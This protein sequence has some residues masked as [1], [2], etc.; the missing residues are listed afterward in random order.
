MFSWIH[1]I[2][3]CKATDQDSKCVWQTHARS[4]VQTNSEIGYK[5]KNHNNEFTRSR[6]YNIQ[7]PRALLA[8]SIT[9][10]KIWKK[11]WRFSNTVLGVLCATHLRSHAEQLCGTWKQHGTQANIGTGTALIAWR[12]TL[13]GRILFLEIPTEILHVLHENGQATT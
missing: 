9:T 5:R 13:Y 12:M 1:N 7:Y 6:L 10:C 8:H 2:T 3:E 11:K 4:C